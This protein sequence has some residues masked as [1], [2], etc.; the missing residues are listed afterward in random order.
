[1]KFEYYALH[2]LFAPPPSGKRLSFFVKFEV[3]VST[4]SPQ[5]AEA[6]SKGQQAYSHTLIQREC[7]EEGRL[8]MTE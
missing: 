5:P 4:F 3:W 8:S 1:V 7:N 2:K 6:D